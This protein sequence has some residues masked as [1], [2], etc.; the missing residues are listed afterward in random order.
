MP[1]IPGAAYCLKEQGFPE[2]RLLGAGVGVLGWELRLDE[3]LVSFS[4]SC[5]HLF[6]A[7]VVA[8]AGVDDPVTAAP[9][10]S[11]SSPISQSLLKLMSIEAVTPSNHLILCHPLLILHSIF[12]SIRVFSKELSLCIRLYLP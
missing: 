8:V 12:P 5:S 10:A 2:R 7:L 11:L 1:P 4:S 6:G 9:Q 3:G